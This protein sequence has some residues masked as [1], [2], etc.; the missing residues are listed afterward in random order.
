MN[1]NDTEEKEPEYDTQFIQTLKEQ[2]E[3]VDSWLNKLKRMLFQTENEEHLKVPQ[4]VNK[5]K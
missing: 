3:K 2:V 5:N 4:K 1:L